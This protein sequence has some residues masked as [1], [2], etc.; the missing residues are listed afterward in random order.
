M[1]PND[2]DLRLA[3]SLGHVVDE[4]SLTCDCSWRPKSP[5]G[6]MPR[7]QAANHIWTVVQEAK[8]ERAARIGVELCMEC[9]GS[10]KSRITEK[11]CGS[12]QGAGLLGLDARERLAVDTGHEPVQSDLCICGHEGSW[13]DHAALIG[14]EVQSSLTQ[15]EGDLRLH[16]ADHRSE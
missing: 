3:A 15:F 4:R 13:S 11:W 10:K 12:C 8:E 9:K 16:G 7:T 5:H 6:V 14:A 2:H 1:W